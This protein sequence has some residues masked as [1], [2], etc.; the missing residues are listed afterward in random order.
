M[1][2]KDAK[3]AKAIRREMKKIELLSRNWLV[4]AD[5]ASA[6]VWKGWCKQKLPLVTF[7]LFC[8]NLVLAPAVYAAA[9][10]SLERRYAWAVGVLILL[11][12]A[13]AGYLFVVV[14]QPERF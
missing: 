10:G 11:T 8:L 14:F 12:L 2:C 9:N 7:V 1:N 6:F 3:N 4:E 13:L 5:I